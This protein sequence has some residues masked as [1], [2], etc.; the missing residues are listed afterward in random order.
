[1]LAQT[2]AELCPSKPKILA[3]SL[4]RIQNEKRNEVLEFCCVCIGAAA[5]S[6]HTLFFLN[7]NEG[8]SP[9]KSYR[10]PKYLHTNLGISFVQTPEDEISQ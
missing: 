3:T 1:M 4:L 5:Y 7:K 6:L 9:Y 2:L 8:L 10:Q